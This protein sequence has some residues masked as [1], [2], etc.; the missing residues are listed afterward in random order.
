MKTV[1]IV[2]GGVGGLFTGAFLSKNGYRV[3]VLEKNAIVGGGLQCFRRSGKIYETGM[4]VT[5][6]FEPGGNL[7]RITRYLGI[8]DNLDLHHIPAEC[9]DEIYYH[10]SGETYR[11]ASGKDGFVESM[12]GYFPEEKDGIRAYVDEI[13][14]ISEE[15]NLFYLRASDDDIVVHSPKFFRPADELISEYVSDPR[16]REV[17]AYLNPL[18]GGV[19]GH[20][21]AYIHALI[22]VLYINGASRFRGGSQQLADSLKRVVEEGGGEVLVN[23]E[24]KKINVA[25][26][27]V[28]SVELVDGRSFT[29]DWYVSAIHP[30]ALVDVLSEGAFHILP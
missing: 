16:L 22:N 27:V 2:G 26:R 4:H 29:A 17:L 13:Y 10:K 18:Y 25:D 11:I 20:T 30:L 7:Y 24:V 21:P 5:G 9:M 3:T 14:R 28:T 12:A 6:G 1:V 8:Y 23:A 15:V 19:Q